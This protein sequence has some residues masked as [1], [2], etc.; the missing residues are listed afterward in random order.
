MQ[1]PAPGTSAA[2]DR[3]DGPIGP[4]P[5]SAEGA[6]LP[7]VRDT[8]ARLAASFAAAVD[9][10]VQIVALE[11]AEERERAKD[12]LVL[13]LVAAIASGF[14]LLAA[15]ALLVVALWDRFGWTTLAALTVAWGLVAWLAVRRM[16]LLARREKRPFDATL[17]EFSRDRAWIAERLGRGP[18]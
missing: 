4:D 6:P 8:L 13:V 17:A 1:E 10:R 18:H 16:A 7:G 11:F 2:S 5:E 3:R 12:R 14:A 9:T 15:N